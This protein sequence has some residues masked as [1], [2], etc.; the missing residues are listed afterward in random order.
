MNDE[1]IMN[2]PY[3]ISYAV[4]ATNFMSNDQAR[5]VLSEEDFMF[6]SCLPVGKCA[7]IDS[8]GDKWERVAA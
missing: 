7:F 3:K 8:D 5:A 6:V 4:G 1:N 2:R